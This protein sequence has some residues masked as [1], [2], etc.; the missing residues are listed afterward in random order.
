M[1]N[2][3][4]RVLESLFLLQLCAFGSFF[5]AFSIVEAPLLSHLN[6]QVS[7]TRTLKHD[8]TIYRSEIFKRPQ[9]IIKLLYIGSNVRRQFAMAITLLTD[10][11]TIDIAAVV[12]PYH[13]PNCGLHQ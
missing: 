11:V 7:M 2:H 9:L 12:S 1:W 6:Q 8:T 4:L 13:L 3:N 10:I 5:L